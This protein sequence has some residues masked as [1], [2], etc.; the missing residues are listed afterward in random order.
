MIIV[1]LQV[2][3]LHSDDMFLE[4]VLQRWLLPLRQQLVEGVNIGEHDS[5]CMARGA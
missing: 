1:M 2:F 3:I 4:L 5:G